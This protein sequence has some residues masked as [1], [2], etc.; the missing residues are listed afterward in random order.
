MASAALQ[1]FPI[2]PADNMSA[3][4]ARRCA[5]WRAVLSS[6]PVNAP[7]RSYLSG[8][9]PRSVPVSRLHD[10]TASIHGSNGQDPHV[11]GWA[12]L[13]SPYIAR[14][15]RYSFGMHVYKN[16]KTIKKT[17]NETGSNDAFPQE[18]QG[19]FKKTMKTTK[20]SDSLCT[21]LFLLFL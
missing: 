11:S 9:V 17:I 7:G 8:P 2:V 15:N 21:H 1:P 6:D 20:I 19:L 5:G 13:N 10:R 12:A 16:I 3:T 14:K 18:F 4:L